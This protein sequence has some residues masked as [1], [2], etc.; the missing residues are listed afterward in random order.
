MTR[1]AVCFNFISH[2]HHPKSVPLCISPHKSR[3]QGGISA[4]STVVGCASE[5]SVKYVSVFFRGGG[6][7]TCNA[8]VCLPE[9]EQLSLRS[10]PVRCSTAG[11]ASVSP[12]DLAQTLTPTKTTRRS[13]TIHQSVQ[14]QA[15]NRCHANCFGQIWP[16]PINKKKK[17][18]T[19]HQIIL[20]HLIFLMQ[21]T[22]SEFL[23]E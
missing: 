13:V 12:F 7:P 17:V 6:S 18:D 19:H 11:K 15:R 14:R 1:A 5:L 2:F 8:V 4:L 21:Y 20:Q 10:R 9:R 22:H 3:T 16:P 23:N